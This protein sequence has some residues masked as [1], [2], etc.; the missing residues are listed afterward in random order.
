MNLSGMTPA[1]R[2]F[3]ALLVMTAGL[4][5][6]GSMGPNYET[7]TVTVSSFRALPS[8]GALPEFE[9]GLHVINPNRQSLVLKGVSY[10]VNLEGRELLKGVGNNLPVIEAY[11]EGDLILTAAV[12]LLAGIGLIADLMS[13]PKD[14]FKY[15]LEAK[16]DV[17]TF[18]PAIRVRDSGEV[19]LRSSAKD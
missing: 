14:S 7:P 15:A 5:A 6:C 12:D 3:L 1:R 10:S 19:S 9:I 4:Q 17:G 2:T 11:G 18:L 13:E 8:Q 16:L